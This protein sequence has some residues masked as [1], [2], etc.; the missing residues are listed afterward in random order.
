MKADYKIKMT[1][2]RSMN[3]LEE[4]N[5]LNTQNSSIKEKKFESPL[6]ISFQFH[7]SLYF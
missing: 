7:F 1:E 5:F 6:G 3:K 2:S 4:N